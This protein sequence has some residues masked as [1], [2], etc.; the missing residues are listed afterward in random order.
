MNA[1]KVKEYMQKIKREMET[2]A[3]YIEATF[4]SSSVTNAMNIPVRRLL[5]LEIFL[6]IHNSFKQDVRLL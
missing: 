3:K 6:Y 5:F 1:N 4:N 2:M